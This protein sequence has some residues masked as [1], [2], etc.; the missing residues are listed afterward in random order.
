MVKESRVRNWARSGPAALQVQLQLKQDQRWLPCKTGKPF[1]GL[2]TVTHLVSAAAFWRDGAEAW[3]EV[4]SSK[5][6][7]VC[8]FFPIPYL[9]PIHQTI[10]ICRSYNQT[11][12]SRDAEGS[13]TWASEVVISKALAAMS[14]RRGKCYLKQGQ[15]QHG[16]QEKEKNPRFYFIPSKITSVILTQGPKCMCY[17]LYI[18]SHS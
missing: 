11:A 13:G 10:K 3:G 7:P 17:W 12:W 9:T 18:S 2:H 1:T 8:L 16:F 5:T 6:A 4:K 15:W 14:C